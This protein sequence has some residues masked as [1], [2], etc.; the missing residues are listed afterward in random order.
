MNH[1][2]THNSRM[3]AEIAGDQHQA[4]LKE[5]DA[6]AKKRAKRDTAPAKGITLTEMSALKG[7]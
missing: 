2:K 1:Y 6:R 7:I 5:R 3:L 4:W